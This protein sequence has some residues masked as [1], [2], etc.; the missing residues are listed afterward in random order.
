MAQTGYTS[1]QLLSDCASEAEKIKRL[2]IKRQNIIFPLSQI[3]VC[4]C[5]CRFIHTQET[6]WA[7]C[8]PGDSVFLC[9]CVFVCLCV[10]DR[11]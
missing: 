3:Y 7:A 4:V 11:K 6:V 9:E 10:R 5:A 2:W 1:V 8:T